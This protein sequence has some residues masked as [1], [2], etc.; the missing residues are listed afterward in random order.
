MELLTQ[1]QQAVSVLTPNFC[2]ALR[3]T[4]FAAR[5]YRDL[6]AKIIGIDMTPALHGAKPKMLVDAPACVVPPTF[7]RVEVTRQLPNIH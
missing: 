2:Q 5:V 4:N 7:G 6:G 1:S 3:D